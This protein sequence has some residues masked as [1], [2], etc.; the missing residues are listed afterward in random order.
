MMEI[1]LREDTDLVRRHT[2]SS[3]MAV[4]TVSATRGYGGH[5]G[6]LIGGGF[7]LVS[8]L[9]V[10]A[11]LTASLRWLSDSPILGVV[12]CFMTIF[13]VISLDVLVLV[14]AKSGIPEGKLV[15]VLDKNRYGSP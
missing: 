5:A 9:V 7:M 15:G 10:I 8:F 4:R 12:A 6:L 1:A 3:E 11:G 13:I 2:V 14:Y